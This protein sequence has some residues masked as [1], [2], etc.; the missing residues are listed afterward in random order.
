MTEEKSLLQRIRD[1]F[2]DWEKRR[3]EERKARCIENINKRTTYQSL[4]EY[5][6]IGPEDLRKDP[7]VRAVYEARKAELEPEKDTG[8]G[9]KVLREVLAAAEDG[10]EKLDDTIGSAIAK[11]ILEYGEQITGVP[12]SPQ[13]ASLLRGTTIGQA[14]QGIIEYITDILLAHQKEELGKIDPEKRDEVERKIRLVFETFGLSA[15]AISVPATI[16]DLLH[17]TKETNLGRVANLIYE[18]VGFRAIRDAYIGP[19]RR[20]LI[21]QPLRYEYNYLIRPWYP[22]FGDVLTAFGRGHI[23]DTQ[24]KRLMSIHGVRPQDEEAKIDFFQMYKRA[25]ANPSSYFMLNAIAREGMYNEEEFKFWLSDAGFGAFPI[26]EEDLTEYERTYGLKAPNRSQ[27]DF[28]AEMYRRMNVR[29]HVGDV[30][31]IKRK[32]YAEG[33]ISR[34]EYEKWLEERNIKREDAKEALDALEEDWKWD[35]KKEWQKTYEKQYLYNRIDVDTLRKKL[36]DLGLREDYVNAR[37]EQLTVQKEGKVREEKIKTLT[38]SQVLR[39]YRE[40][41]IPRDEAYMRLD[42]HG[43][44]AEDIELLLREQDLKIQEKLEK[45]MEK[46]EKE[47]TAPE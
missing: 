28:L 32:L 7:D 21:E 23:G 8:W 18:M 30:R 41:L 35:I 25:A 12:P 42:A 27:I 5:W 36:S 37:I 40:G 26:H 24:F 19:L 6:K 31:S 47:E 11:L 45:E 4:E 33:A 38:P 34:E 1:W 9:G 2:D 22:S 14:Y 29:T 44:S 43:Y 17:P 3:Y 39:M 46:A 16:G 15:A 13:T 20:A 10:L